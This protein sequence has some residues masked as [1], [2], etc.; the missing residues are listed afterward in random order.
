MTVFFFFTVSHKGSISHFDIPFV[1]SWEAGE[2]LVPKGFLPADPRHKAVDGITSF[3][4]ASAHTKVPQKTERSRF[5]CTE[6]PYTQNDLFD[7]G[8]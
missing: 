6:H 4:E 3:A 7:L 8:F 1:V 2:D 5:P